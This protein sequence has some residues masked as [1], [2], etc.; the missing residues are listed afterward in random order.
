MATVTSFALG[1]LQTN[2]FLVRAGDRALAVDPG[3]DPSSVVGYL[4]QEG[5][6][7]T[8]ILNTHL[9]F[10]HILGNRSLSEA[11]GAPILANPEDHFLLDT[12]VGGGGFMGFPPTPTFEYQP[13][14]PG[15]TSFLG[16]PCTVLKTPGH[17]P[18]SLSLYFPDSAM[19]FSGDLIFHHSIGRTDFPGGNQQTLI[20]SVR[21]KIFT[22]PEET[23]IYSGH[24]PKTTVREEK[25]HNPFFNR[26]FTL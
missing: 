8:H 3:G 18:G 11:T 19:V 4:E 21:G 16:E 14:E 22:L 6:T 12:E 24:G 9:H 23:V 15:E 13:L 20:D 25:L 2:C 26:G 10:D 5:V 7:L 17:T 1:P